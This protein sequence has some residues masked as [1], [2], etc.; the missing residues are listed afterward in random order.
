[1]LLKIALLFPGIVL[2]F[3]VSAICGG[4]ASLILIPLL[5]LLLPAS[6]IPFSL[7][8]GTFASAASRII[9]FRKHVNTRIFLWFIP[10]SIPAVLLGAWLIKFINPLYL[11]FGVALFL[12]FNIPQ[13][14][15]SG[16]EL[17]KGEKPYPNYML[18]LVGFLCG[19][20]S[21]VIGAVGVLFNRFYLRY[22]LSK[23]EI[24]ATRA[25]N[26]VYLHVIKLVVYTSLDLYSE[27]ALSLGLLIAL[28]AVVSSFSIKFI[29]PLI[30]NFVF[31]KAGYGAMVASGFIMLFSTSSHIIEQDNL[32]FISQNKGYENEVAISWRNSHF[33]LEYDVK[34]GKFGIEWP[35][36][37]ED[38]PQDLKRYF[39]ELKDQYDKILLEK[40]FRFQGVSSY[41]FYCY[42][43]DALTRI[44][45]KSVL[46]AR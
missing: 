25:A 28:A 43:N 40:V 15:Q 13:L 24:I 2:T 7:T 8:L 5:S 16:K 1:M 41:E 10:F 11:Q 38:L 34:D 17:Q 37:Y 12:L 44:D 23:E 31:R 18:A 14:L 19:F 45:F 22:G 36:G 3:W 32:N 39:D 4:G 9:V 33:V 42:K 29:L 27:A 26:E 46:T 21:G 30:S 20:V 35:V 6:L